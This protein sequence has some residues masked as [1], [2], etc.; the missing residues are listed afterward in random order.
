MQEPVVTNWG[1]M[2]EPVVTNWGGMQEPVV[3]SSPSKL[4]GVP[5]RAGAC[6]TSKL[7]EACVMAA[8]KTHSL[9]PSGYSP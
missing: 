3:N 7:A 4:E 6:V 1:G 8:E 5:V 2:Q 9:P